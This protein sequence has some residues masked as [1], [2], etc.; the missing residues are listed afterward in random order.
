MK[1]NIYFGINYPYDLTLNDILKKKA[2]FFIWDT[3]LQRYLF[4]FS[5]SQLKEIEAL[6]SEFI[7]IPGF[8]EKST[9]EDVIIPK[10]K[11]VDFVEIFEYPKIYQII[12]HRKLEDMSVKTIKHSINKELVDLV[13]KDVV[14]LQPLHKPIKTRT[15]AEKICGKL[16][17]DRFNRQSGTFDFA[18]FFGNRKD[19]YR[20]FYLP[21]KVLAWQG[22]VVHHK[23]GF[24][25][26][27]K[28]I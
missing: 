11:G 18:K 25:E 5:Y 23:A 17:I 1:A 8:R 4:I 21:L 24:V 22:K 2:I 27:S 15:V 12:E 20:Y 9:R 6:I 10:F 16:G 3:R 7:V 14:G 19:Y 13:W 26:K 28:S